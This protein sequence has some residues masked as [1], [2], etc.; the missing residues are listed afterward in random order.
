M[1][2]EGR[3]M[4]EQKRKRLEAA[5]WVETTVQEFLDLDDADISYI[6]LKLALSRALKARRLARNLTQAQFA[7]AIKSSQSRV[8]KMEG[9]DP[10]VSVDLLM[11]SLF[12]L[13]TTIEEMASLILVT[14]G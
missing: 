6:Q 11:R 9:G 7:K 2:F 8:A 12:A 13:E 3:Q 1:L 5:G 10:S 14:A 4:D